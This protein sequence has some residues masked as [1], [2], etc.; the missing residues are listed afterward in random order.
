MGAVGPVACTGDE[1][2]RWQG[3]A[4]SSRPCPMREGSQD[5]QEGHKV[6]NVEELGPGGQH[7]WPQM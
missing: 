6:G 1:W 7:P 5:D 4:L 3:S 2:G